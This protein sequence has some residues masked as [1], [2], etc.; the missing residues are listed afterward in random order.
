MTQPL[1][2]LVICCANP[3]YLTAASTPDRAVYLTG[4]HVN[5]NF[6]GGDS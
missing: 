4:S 2:P 1:G 5:N 3:R 6:H